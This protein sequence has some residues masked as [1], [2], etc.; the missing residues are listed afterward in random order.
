MIYLGVVKVDESK[1]LIAATSYS[2]AQNRMER[3]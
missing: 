1:A 2:I 3:F